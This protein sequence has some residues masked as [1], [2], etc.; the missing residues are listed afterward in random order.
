LHNSGAI[1]VSS[2]DRVHYK[3]SEEEVKRE[4]I[5]M[6]IKEAD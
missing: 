5:K 4:Y 1:V 6:E 3:G 2:Q